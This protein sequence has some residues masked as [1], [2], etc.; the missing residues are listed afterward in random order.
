MPTPCSR[1]IAGIDPR[2][3]EKVPGGPLLHHVD[4]STHPI[5]PQNPVNGGTW[6]GR[7]GWMGDITVEFDAGSL[8]EIARLQLE[9]L[10]SEVMDEMMVPWEQVAIGDR[11][12]AGSFGEVF[13]GHAVK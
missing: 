8:A 1:F 6:W 5:S 11:L 2:A 13:M 7:S 4:P 10:A 3:S 12:G 9:G